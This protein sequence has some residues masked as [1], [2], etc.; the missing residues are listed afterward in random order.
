[1]TNS[2]IYR[3]LFPPYTCMLYRGPTAVPIISYGPCI[4]GVRVSIVDDTMHDVVFI[5]GCLPM[6]MLLIVK[7][8]VK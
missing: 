4:M 1:M 6:H 7:K 5:T 8:T 3:P 2:V